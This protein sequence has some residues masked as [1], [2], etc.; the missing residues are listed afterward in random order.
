MQLE[1]TLQRPLEDEFLGLIVEVPRLR[2]E[3]P[4]DL[5]LAGVKL[6]KEDGGEQEILA[7]PRDAQTSHDRVFNAVIL[8]MVVHAFERG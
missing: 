5:V 8:D 4:R 6:A 1:E 2:K 3:R 7:C